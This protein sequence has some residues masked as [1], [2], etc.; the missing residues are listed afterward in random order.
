MFKKIKLWL[1]SAAITLGIFQGVRPGTYEQISTTN[2]IKNMVIKNTD[3]GDLYPEIIFKEFVGTSEEKENTI[4][5]VFLVNT[6]LKSECFRREIMSSKLTETNG[7]DNVGV[8]KYLSERKVY[9]NVEFF[10][11]NWKQNYL[12]KTI[13]YETEPF[14]GWT[15]INRHF[16]NSAYLT[17]SNIIHEVVGHTMG[18]SHRGNKS[19]SVPYVLNDVYEKCFEE[20]GLKE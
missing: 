7:M 1:Y 4:R 16:V 6:I 2:E 5:A 11:G 15:Y 17:G 18:F 10:N 9:A 14:D 12:W 3:Q 19:T 8:I 13:G 20:L